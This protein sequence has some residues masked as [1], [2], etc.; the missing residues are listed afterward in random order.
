MTLEYLEYLKMILI[1]QLSI[2]GLSILD[3]MNSYD[4]M[5]QSDL[6]CIENLINCMTNKK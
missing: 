3:G 5:Y 1:P 2:Y 4:V 6:Q